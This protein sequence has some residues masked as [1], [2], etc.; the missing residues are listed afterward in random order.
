MNKRKLGAL[1]AA[2]T[3]SL[4]FAGTALANDVHQGMPIVGTDFN[5]TV[6]GCAEGWHFV[7]I[8]TNRESLPSTLT[9]TFKD[10]GT[11]KVDGHVNGNSIV[12]Y[13]VHVDPSDRLLSASDDISNDGLL[14]LSHVCLTETTSSETTSNETTANE[15]TSV[16]TT[17]NETTTNETTTT[18][19]S[20]TGDDRGGDGGTTTTTSGSTTAGDSTSGDSTSGGS[21]TGDSTSGEA[22]PVGHVEGVTPPATDTIGA[23]ASASNV[24]TSLLLVMAGTLSFVLLGTTAVARKRR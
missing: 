13:N 20:S 10:A 6:V 5:N 9:A 11:V 2:A 18:D 19:A 4:T 7:H 21:T 24:S 17:A 8:G 3:L 1:V 15:T 12:M 16:E 23:P 14:N 22:A